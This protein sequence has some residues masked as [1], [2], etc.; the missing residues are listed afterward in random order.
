LNSA[1]QD[2]VKLKKNLHMSINFSST[3]VMPLLNKA[4]AESFGDI[5]HVK[6]ALATTGWNPLNRNCLLLPEVLK[7]KPQEES[8]VVTPGTDPEDSMPPLTGN[9]TVQINLEGSTPAALLDDILNARNVEE[10]RKRQEAKNRTAN[11]AKETYEGT[12]KITSGKLVGLGEHELTS[13]LKDHIVTHENNKREKEESAK[14]KKQE[15]EV[16]LHQ[17]VARVRSKKR[18]EWRLKDY[19]TLNTYKKHKGD[20]PLK[21]NLPE[22]KA[23]YEKRKDRPSPAKPAKYGWE[24]NL[25]S[26][27]VLPSIE[28]EEAEEA[29][30]EEASPMGRKALF[31]NDLIT[32][33][34]LAESPSVGIVGNL[35]S[36]VPGP[37]APLDQFISTMLTSPDKPLDESKP[38]WMEMEMEAE[39]EVVPV[40]HFPPEDEA[41]PFAI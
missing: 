11:R 10:V 39:A 13:T 19:N 37:W 34:T 40:A 30:E 4:W 6:S 21:K 27:I 14:N 38:N 16:K 33:A 36:T 20:S 29:A 8:A 41:T 9:V 28:E 5:E 23:Q 24:S 18:G 3:D 25:D 15:A 22:A 35:S 26:Y 32:L 1:K 2:L 12:K 17:D 31:H 7:T